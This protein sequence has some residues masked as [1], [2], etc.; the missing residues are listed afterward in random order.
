[1]RTT[2]WEYWAYNFICS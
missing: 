2:E 1:L